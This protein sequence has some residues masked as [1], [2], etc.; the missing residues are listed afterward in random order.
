MAIINNNLY[1]YDTV[2]DI[3]YTGKSYKLDNTS[4]NTRELKVHKGVENTL[5]FKI[6]DRD[7]K[8]QNVFNSRLV[9][10]IVDPQSRSRIL[11]QE[12][13]VGLQT[14]ECKLVIAP[15]DLIN[16]DTGFYEMFVTILPDG[17]PEQPL[18]SNQN[19]DLKFDLHVTDQSYVTPVDTQ[20]ISQ[21]FLADAP[22]NSYV[23]S[24]FVGNQENNY[25]N[26]QH[27]MSIYSQGYSGNL[28]IQA[29]L[30][31]NSPQGSYP[32]P[33]WAD[34]FTVNLS[35]TT[36][37][38]YFTFTVNTNWIRVVNQPQDFSAAA[39]IAQIQLRN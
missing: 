34:L 20:T 9:A 18:Y 13:V 37:I 12:C 36:S 26:P 8:S 17:E 6:T 38:Q 11:V 22:S 16:I 10:T 39:N 4:M 1:L 32:N 23:S 14:G 30:V 29:S 2:I 7:R 15:G 21:W 5:Y 24:A 33:E 27:S 31:E 28:T 25:S 3:T 35:N 19:N